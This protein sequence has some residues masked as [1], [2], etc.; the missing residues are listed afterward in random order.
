MLFCTSMLISSCTS[1]GEGQKKSKENGEK[2]NDEG[3]GTKPQ[4]STKET[5][6]E[7]QQ[8]SGATT[9][10]KREEAQRRLNDLEK[11]YGTMA[12][13]KE[14]IEKAQK[15]LD[16]IL[17]VSSKEELD[18]VMADFQK[19][20]LNAG[21]GIETGIERGDLRRS[22]VHLMNTSVEQG[23]QVKEKAQELLNIA[24]THESDFLRPVDIDY[25]R[26]TWFNNVTQYDAMLLPEYANKILTEIKNEARDKVKNKFIGVLKEFE[27][28]RIT[29]RKAIVERWLKFNDAAL[30][31]MQTEEAIL[32]G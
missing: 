14:M 17:R 4:K 19:N 20:Q 16:E 6:E 5:G 21:G 25:V 28:P 2:G 31:K 7:G 11:N 12:E 9:P 22:F 10:A 13:V 24:N 1:D 26:K 8:R 3:S 32:K 30:K 23:K 15:T 18:K 27:D 29:V